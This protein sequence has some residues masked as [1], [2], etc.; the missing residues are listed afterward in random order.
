MDRILLEMNGQRRAQEN[1]LR[2]IHL[3]DLVATPRSN[4][5]NNNIDEDEE[6]TDR[7]M[8]ITWREKVDAALMEV[9]GE[10][11]EA[12]H[13]LENDG[14]LAVAMEAMMLRAD[15]VDD[16]D[17]EVDEESVAFRNAMLAI[18]CCVG[19]KRC[20]RRDLSYP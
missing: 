11:E 1:L 14:G 20:H 8:L 10:R 18:C 6:E 15:K 19:G 2:G 13:I 3:P 16:E 4:S 5:S 17:D 12:N 7:R 9:R